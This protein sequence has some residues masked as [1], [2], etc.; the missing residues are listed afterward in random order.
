MKIMSF[1][2]RFE[3]DRDGENSWCY[4][5]EL[6]VEVIREYSPAVLGVQEGTQRQLHTLRDHLPQYRMQALGRFWDETCQY[7]TLFCSGRTV[8]RPGGR[9]ILA[10]QNSDRPPQQRL[11]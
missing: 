2:L 8:P 6:V 7:P 3:N 11:G 10:F 1:N 5:A 9:R 4:R